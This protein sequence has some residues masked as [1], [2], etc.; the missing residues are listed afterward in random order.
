MLFE[1]IKKFS[2]ILKSTIAT[3]TNEQIENDFAFKNIVQLLNEK[4]DLSHIYLIGNG[5][6]SG[7]VSHGAIDFLNAC[8]FKAHALT[9]NSML[10]CMA[11]DYGYENVFSQPLKTLISNNDVIIAISSSGNSKN[12]INACK[13]AKSRGAIVITF[14]G[15]QQDNELRKLGHFNFW[16]NCNDYG[17]VEIG[18]ALLLHHLTDQL[19]I[20]N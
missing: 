6:S 18:H 16:I 1:Y 20:K 2:E 12:I 8:G 7:I 19:S 13:L 9:D 10:T 4:R 15:F 17:I 3:D 14:S 5:G 11:N